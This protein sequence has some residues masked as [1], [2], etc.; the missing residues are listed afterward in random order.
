MGLCKAKGMG[1]HLQSQGNSSP[2]PGDTGRK[3]QGN[4]S[5]DLSL[6]SGSCSDQAQGDTEVGGSP[7]KSMQ[8]RPAGSRRGGGCHH[9][10]GPSRYKLC[11]RLGIYIL[12]NHSLAVKQP[13][14]L[15]IPISCQDLYW[16]DSVRSWKASKPRSC[17]LLGKEQDRGGCSES[18]GG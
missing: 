13:L 11:L 15:F 14:F 12:P 10:Q 4:K 16:L 6:P 3:S 1:C 9:G 5:Q 7:L 8:T 18:G 2:A 17:S